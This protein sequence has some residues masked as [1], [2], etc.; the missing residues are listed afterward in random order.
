MNVIENSRGRPVD[1]ELRGRRSGEILDVAA[2]LF[3]ERGYAG[4]DTQ[5]L[6]DRVGVE[7]DRHYQ[8]QLRAPGQL[9]GNCP[10]STAG[11][12]VVAPKS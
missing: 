6:A 10:I 7:A 8:L 11:A 5:E 3:A 2:T 12:D 1:E 9:A 4:A